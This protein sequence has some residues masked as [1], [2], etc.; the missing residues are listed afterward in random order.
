VAEQQVAATLDAFWS[1]GILD[2]GPVAPT[3]TNPS[4]QRIII[5]HSQVNPAKWL[6]LAAQ[7]ICTLIAIAMLH[8]D[9]WRASVIMPR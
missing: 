5:S 8:S 7:A 1:Y 9:N 4:Q 3:P 6:C 2:G